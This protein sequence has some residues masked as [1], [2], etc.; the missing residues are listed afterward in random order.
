MI[1]FFYVFV[2][3]F[4]AYVIFLNRKKLLPIYG[5]EA[6]LRSFFVNFF[7]TSI[8]Q[9]VGIRCFYYSHGQL[10]WMH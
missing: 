7:R 2:V 3:F 5:K 8:L 10:L 6:F 1:I 9:R 4:S